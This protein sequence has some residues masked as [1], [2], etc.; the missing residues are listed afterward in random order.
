M[1]VG[2]HHRRQLND[3]VVMVAAVVRSVKSIK[4]YSL[5]YYNTII[6]LT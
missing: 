3:V 1:V 5:L 6:V 2:H 4:R